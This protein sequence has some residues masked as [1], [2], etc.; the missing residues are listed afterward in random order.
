MTAEERQRPEREGVW[1]PL[2]SVHSC[3]SVQGRSSQ[4]LGLSTKRAKRRRHRRSL[5]SCTREMVRGR[6]EVGQSKPRSCLPHSLRPLELTQLGCLGYGQPA[7]RKHHGQN[8]LQHGLCTT[9]SMLVMQRAPAGGVNGQRCEC[10]RA[11]STTR[12]CDSPMKSYSITAVVAAPIR[13]C[14]YAPSSLET[15]TGWD[16]QGSSPSPL[17]RTPSQITTDRSSANWHSQQSVCYR[18][19][20]RSIASTTL[21]EAS[22]QQLS[23]GCDTR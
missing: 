11:P 7:A 1:R 18:E 19:D 6:E 16:E 4:R 21:L 9:R 22:Q 20:V 8:A 2:G 12:Q 10:R 23:S 17:L 15:S 13:I 3:G 5:R 14:S